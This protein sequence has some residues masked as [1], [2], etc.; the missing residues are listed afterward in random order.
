PEVEAL[1]ADVSSQQEIHELARQYRQR[2]ARLDVLINNAGGMW[3][4]RELTMDG[5]EMTFAVNHL[6]YFLL[7]MLLLDTLR[8]SA[9]ARIVNVASAAHRKATL[10]FD[11]LQG[12]RRYGGWQTYC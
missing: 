9:P 11:N 7:T 10:D 4:K 2:H 5:V 1:L 3:L 8:A 12:E 6:A